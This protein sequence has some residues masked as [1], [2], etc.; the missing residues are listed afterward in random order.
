MDSRLLLWLTSTD[1]PQK[2]GDKIQEQDIAPVHYESDNEKGSE[3]ANGEQSLS[4]ATVALLDRLKPAKKANE[5]D[6]QESRPKIIFCSRTHSQL[7]QFANE[8]KKVNIP[9]GLSGSQDKEVIKHIPL[10]SRKNLCLNPR[11][12]RLTSTLA[13]NERCL[14]LQKP[15]LADDKKCGLKPSKMSSDD[16][17]RVEDFR[18][19]AIAQ[20]QDIE[21]IANLGRKMKLCPYYASRAAIP[22]TEVVT[23]PYPLLLQRTA[24]EALGVELK[25][26]VVII[27]EAHNLNSAIAD[28][29]SVIMPLSHLDLAHQQLLEYCQKFQKKLKGKNSTYIVQIIRLIKSCKSRLEQ[30]KTSKNAETTLLANDL[31]SAVKGADQIQPHKLVRYIQESKLVYKVEGYAELLNDEIQLANTSTAKQNQPKGV[32]AE[33]QNLLAVIMNPATEG[34]F[35]I[36]RNDQEVVLKYTLLDPQAHFE[37]IVKEARAVILAGG[38]MSPMSDWSEQLFSYV[39]P[40]KL[41]THSFGHI[42]NKSNVLVQPLM[43]GPTNTEFDFTF[44]NR[45]NERMIVDLGKAIRNLCANTPDGMVVFFP[46]YDY[47]ALV[48]RIW[49]Q[50]QIKGSIFDRLSV[51]KRVFQESREV[52]VEELLRDYAHAISTGKGALMLAVVGGKLSEGINFADR[53][54]RVVICVGL[55]YPNIRSAEWKAKV[56]YVEST[57]LERLK[58]EGVPETECRAKAQAAGREYADNITMR[59]VNQSIGRAIRHKND[60]AAIY[61]VDKRYATPRI[62]AKLPAWLKD[63]IRSGQKTWQEVQTDYGRFFAARN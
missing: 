14:E 5:E 54:G 56:E 36:S 7:S 49:K 51:Y 24:R 26:N 45:Q 62:Q 46:S 37:D 16:A 2:I 58:Q 38:T 60:Y 6:E 59:A 8:L 32:L 25:G 21:D 43:T 19:S 42:I 12:N 29:M 31:I 20:I 11:V 63:S 34:R 61:L 4:S 17:Q 3:A 33:F 9:S 50:Q 39:T 22:P 28:T 15:S 47:L 27:D 35:F 53:L 44:G 30:A 13:I 40:E 18:D 57:K 23:L 41:E 1:M 52:V 55:P 10:G 48:T